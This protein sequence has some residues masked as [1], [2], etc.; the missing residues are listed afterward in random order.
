MEQV[1]GGNKSKKNIRISDSKIGNFQE[2]KTA[3]F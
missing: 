3:I 1:E 2:K